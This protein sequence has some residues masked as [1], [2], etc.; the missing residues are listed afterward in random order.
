MGFV[1]SSTLAS[2][3]TSAVTQAINNEI[4]AVAN[5]EQ[6]LVLPTDI[7]GYIIKS[8]GATGEI[9]LSHVSTESGTKFIT[10]PKGAVYTDEHSYSALT[11]FFQSPVA[12]MVVEIVTWA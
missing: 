11:L 7:V 12:S 1:N 3:A 2:A 10:I 9:K 5:V 6:S 4:I 8:R